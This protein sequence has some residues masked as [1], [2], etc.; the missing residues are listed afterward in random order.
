MNLADLP[1]L[2]ENLYIFKRSVHNYFLSKRPHI[3]RKRLRSSQ[4]GLTTI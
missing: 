4:V 2:T 3:N 1:H